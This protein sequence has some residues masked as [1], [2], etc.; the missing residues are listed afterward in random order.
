MSLTSEARGLHNCPRIDYYHQY[1]YCSN[2]P[3][4]IWFTRIRACTADHIIYLDKLGNAE[5]RMTKVR[6]GK[7]AGG[8][9]GEGWRSFVRQGCPNSACV[10]VLYVRVSVYGVCVRVGAC[11]VVVYRCVRI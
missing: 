5:D 11:Y 10:R 1:L 6:G 3:S 2:L 9:R 4:T 7:G 8:G